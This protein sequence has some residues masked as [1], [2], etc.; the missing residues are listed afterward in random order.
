[1]ANYHHPL[2]PSGRGGH[3]EITVTE[4]GR[5]WVWVRNQNQ[6]TWFQVDDPVKR[7]IRNRETRLSQCP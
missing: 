5:W 1:M 2:V 7:G 3:G 6:G 4:D